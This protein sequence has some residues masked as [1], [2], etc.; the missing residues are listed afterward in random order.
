MELLEFKMEMSGRPSMDQAARELLLAGDAVQPLAHSLRS[1][2][3]QRPTAQGSLEVMVAETA[4]FITDDWVVSIHSKKLTQ[5][6]AAMVA[7]LNC[8]SSQLGE[9]PDVKLLG[10]IHR[11]VVSLDKAIRQDKLKRNLLGA[12]KW[13]ATIL[14]SAGAGAL[15][16]WSISQGA[17]Q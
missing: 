13:G 7:L 10:L 5:C 2:I 8:T 3:P 6:V 1:R 4:T 11:P 16:Q 9:L 17:T 15:L 14:V 12:A